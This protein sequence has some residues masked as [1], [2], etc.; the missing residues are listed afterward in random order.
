MIAAEF[1]FVY[2]PV[3]YLYDHELH[4][5]LF[6]VALTILTLHGFSLSY[7]HHPMNDQGIHC[8]TFLASRLSM[9]EHAIQQH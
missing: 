4:V 5:Y 8:Q 2:T 7:C 3:K 9:F 6:N 1:L